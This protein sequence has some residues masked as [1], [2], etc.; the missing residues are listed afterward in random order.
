MI[1]D[2]FLNRIAGW[3]NGES[4]DSPSNI[5]FSSSVITPDGTETSLPSEYG[6]SSADGT[7]ILSETTYNGLRSGAIASSTGDYINSLGLLTASTG[8]DLL[9]EALVPSVLHTTSFDFEVDWT[10]TVDRK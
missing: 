5:A 9:V 3:I 4:G 6:R 8:G 10:I 1:T 7:R 2:T